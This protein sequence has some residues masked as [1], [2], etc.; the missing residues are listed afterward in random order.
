MPHAL[1][2]LALLAGDLDADRL[3]RIDGAVNSAIKEGKTPGAVVLVVRKDKVA[4]RKA[5]GS[6]ALKPMTEEMKVDTLFDKKLYPKD[7]QTKRFDVLLVNKAVHSAVE[8]GESAETI[9]KM[10]RGELKKFRAVRGK[11]LLYKE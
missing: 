9:L 5:Y 6:R 8:K 10:W 4:F 11:Y 1:C 3:A 7:W 2:L